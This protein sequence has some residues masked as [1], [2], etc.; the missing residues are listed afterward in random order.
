M[1]QNKNVRLIAFPFIDFYYSFLNLTLSLMYY[2]QSFSDMV[3]II[4]INI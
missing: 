1:K 3:K 4:N 2:R